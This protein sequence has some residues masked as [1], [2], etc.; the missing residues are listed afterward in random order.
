MSELDSFLVEVGNQDL[1]ENLDI[2][3][4]NYKE[5]FAKIFT[6]NE[7]D[8][9]KNWE[10]ALYQDIIFEIYETIDSITSKDIKDFIKTYL[11]NQSPI[12]E[13]KEEI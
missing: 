8:L 1:N 2:L 11:I 4:K 9:I 10:L 3:K 6:K 13:K 7:L 5:Y 12:I